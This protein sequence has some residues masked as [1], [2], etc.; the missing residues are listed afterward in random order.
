MKHLSPLPPFQVKS[1]SPRVELELAHVRVTTAER[2]LL[3]C[4]EILVLGRITKLVHPDS[5]VGV[6]AQALLVHAR[7]SAKTD[8]RLAPQD[9]NWRFPNKAH[10][11]LLQQ[12]IHTRN[13]TKVTQSAESKGHMRTSGSGE[14]CNGFSSLDYG[15]GTE[16]PAFSSVSD[17]GLEDL[18]ELINLAFAVDEL[19]GDATWWWVLK[20]LKKEEEEEDDGNDFSSS[21]PDREEAIK[22]LESVLHVCALS[23]DSDAETEDLEQTDLSKQQA[24]MQPAGGYF[25]NAEGSKLKMIASMLQQHRERCDQESTH[26]S[27][28]IFVSTRKLAMATPGMLQAMPGLEDIVLADSIVGLSEMTLAQQRTSLSQFR[29][30]HLNVLVSTSVCG[31]GIDVP[32]CGLVIC[33]ALPNSGTALV[34]LRGRIRCGVNC[35]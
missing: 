13:T 4:L 16:G 7:K 35:R 5:D 9:E 17:G 26:F 2:D 1:R 32:T 11:V 21:D 29:D 22:I 14:I 18:R 30:G 12:A 20:A 25:G 15:A 24:S 10:V 3:R 33:T 6:Q 19:G 28:L 23:N 8:S 27:A 31:E 34:Q